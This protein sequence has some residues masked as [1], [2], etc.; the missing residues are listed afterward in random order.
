MIIY[1]LA[2]YNVALN[3]KATQDSTYNS[4][5]DANHAVDGDTNKNYGAKSCTHTM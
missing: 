5:A 1:H 3:K 4:N 2:A